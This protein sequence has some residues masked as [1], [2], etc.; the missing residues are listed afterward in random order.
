MGV[1]FDLLTRN[2]ALTISMVFIVVSFIFYLVQFFQKN[3]RTVPK[4]LFFSSLAFYGINHISFNLEKN[5]PKDDFSLEYEDPHASSQEIAV[6]IHGFP[7][8]VIRDEL[9]DE[10]GL[11][12]YIISMNRYPKV[13]VYRYFLGESLRLRAEKLTEY[14]KKANLLSKENNAKIGLYGFSIGGLIARSALQNS[15]EINAATRYLIMIGTPNNGVFN[16]WVRYIL[17]LVGAYPEAIEA[18]KGSSY[19]A[20]LNSDEGGVN[21]ALSK[22]YVILSN[23]FDDSDTLVKSSSGT[24]DRH[25]RFMLANELSDI[26]DKTKHQ[27]IFM[28]TNLPSFVFINGVGTA[29]RNILREID[30][31]K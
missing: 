25:F 18:T 14:L 22:S 2:I 23:L 30:Q 7:F 19:L 6:I 16:S 21:N 10:Q 20:W 5:L 13:Y 15:S 3:S 9:K 31:K 26:Q 24:E 17:Q 11:L 12:K 4:I 28:H 27:E 1:L 29:I 8:G